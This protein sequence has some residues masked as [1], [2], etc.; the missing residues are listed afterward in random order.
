MSAMVPVDLVDHHM[1]EGADIPVTI[2]DESAPA[3]SNAAA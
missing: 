2:A 3:A 1:I